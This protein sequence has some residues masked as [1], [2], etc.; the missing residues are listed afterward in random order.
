MEF[1]SIKTSDMNRFYITHNVDQYRYQ[2]QKLFITFPRLPLIACIAFVSHFYHLL[3][4]HRAILA[5]AFHARRE[6]QHRD[7]DKKI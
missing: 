7:D 1:I 4:I 5:R 6:A 3:N 2:P